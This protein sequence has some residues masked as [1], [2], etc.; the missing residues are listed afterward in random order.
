MSNYPT[1]TGFLDDNRPEIEK[2]KDFLH[3]ELDLGSGAKWLSKTEALKSTKKYKKLDQKRTSSCV[4]HSGVLALGI[5]NESE[6]EGF[7]EL[8]PAYI[9]RQRFNFPQEGMYYHDLGKIC[10]TNGSCFSETL[11]T[12]VFE[13]DINNVLITNSMIQEGR[14]FRS[15]NYVFLTAPKMEQFKNI[16][17]GMKEAVIISVFADYKEWSTD[18]PKL[19]KPNLKRE[20]A[21]IRHACV[22]LP[23][24]AYEYRGVRYLIV[25][26]SAWFG[27]K[28]IRHVPEDFVLARF[29]YGMYFTNLP[30]P[31]PAPKKEASVSFQYEFT[32]NLTTGMRGTDVKKL[33]MALKELGF[34]TYPKCT[35]YFG[36]V[37][38]KAVIDFQNHFRNEVLK[39]FG[40]SKGTGYFGRTSK[41]K[42]HKLMGIE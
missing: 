16:S 21:P 8:S 11:P 15:K 17:N 31:K 3:E 19:L 30:N 26:D 20:D 22:V 33:Q 1:N 25:Q 34:F 23:N 41:A 37:T 39:V 4:G 36:G 32:R 5:E 12:P 29:R 7:V 24:S 42:M 13:R 35:G 18:K 14:T 28:N 38:R 6:G 9:Y 10:N 27:G 40:I 2:G